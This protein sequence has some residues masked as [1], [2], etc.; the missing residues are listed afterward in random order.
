VAVYAD[1]FR[2]R[3]LFLNLFSRDL[4]V[5]HKGSVLGLG[6]TL[7]NPLVLMGVYTLLF[8]ILLRAVSVD[9]FPLFV[10]SG[11]LSWVF[12][13]STLQAST[14]SLLGHGNLIK[15]V[16][17]PRQLL[18]L[19]VVATN[20]VTLLAMLAVIAP[21]DLVLL[22]GTRSTIWVVFPLLLPL[23]GLVSG[24]AIVFACLNVLFRDIEHLLAAVIFPWFVLTPIFYTFDKLPGLADH[25][26]VVELMHWGNF[27]V[28]IVNTIRDPLFFGRMPFVGDVIYAVAAALIALVLGAVV[29]RQVDDQLAAEL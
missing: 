18:P 6:W 17:F 23:I 9:H 13:Q 28:P 11:L 2:Y 1:V 22:P 16:R 24:L 27:V 26:W 14:T 29:F 7:V 21:F 5:K 20:L 12:F 19:S 15:Q 8:S 10:L 4:R 25:R 3:E